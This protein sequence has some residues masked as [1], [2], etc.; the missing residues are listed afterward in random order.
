MHFAVVKNSTS[1]EH[2]ANV[3][4]QPKAHKTECKDDQKKKQPCHI[5]QSEL[6]FLILN[7]LCKKLTDCS[8]PELADGIYLV[9]PSVNLKSRGRIHVTVD[10]TYKTAGDIEKVFCLWSADNRL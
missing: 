8:K 10:T 1:Q 6:L 5:Q 2:P 4:V 7:K 9:T 3:C